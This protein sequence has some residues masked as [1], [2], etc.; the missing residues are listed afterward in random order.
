MGIFGDTDAK[1]I[2]KYL[3]GDK[4]ALS[5][6]DAEYLAKMVDSGKTIIDTM[7]YVDPDL[8]NNIKFDALVSLL[9]ECGIIPKEAFLAA[10]VYTFGSDKYK[11]NATKFADLTRELSEI[12]HSDNS[13]TMRSIK[14]ISAISK[15][16]TG[17]KDTNDFISDLFEGL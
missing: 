10:F 9:D 4:K 8:C 11:N 7:E 12:K 16:K 3:T 17:G 14:T 2:I 15:Y 6:Q 13:D 1:D 5:E